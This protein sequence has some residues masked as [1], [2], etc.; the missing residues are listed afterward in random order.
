MKTKSGKIAIAGI[1]LLTV[2]I[3]VCL[4]FI[5]PNTVGDPTVP[6]ET[7][8][9]IP[10]ETIQDLDMVSVDK[11]GDIF[12]AQKDGFEFENPKTNKCQLS[13]KVVCGDITLFESE[14][15]NPGEKV[16][17]DTKKVGTGFYDSYVIVSTKNVESGK[18]G[19]SFS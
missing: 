12:I 11:Y 5:K 19:N 6:S 4:I 1:A 3:A 9:T 8:P 10:I 16:K 17:W 7:T 13:F 14:F 15:I 18:E 2:I